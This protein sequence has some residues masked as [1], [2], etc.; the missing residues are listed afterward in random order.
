[1]TFSTDRDPTNDE[2][3]AAFILARNKAIKNGEQLIENA[4]TIMRFN[5]IGTTVHLYKEDTESSGGTITA[6]WRNSLKFVLLAIASLEVFCYISSQ[7]D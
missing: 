7:K 6:K 2:I 1:M 4:P 5:G 3:Q